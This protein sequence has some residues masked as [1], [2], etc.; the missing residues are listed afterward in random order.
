MNLGK[1]DR[2]IL[3]EEPTNT[4]DE[5]GSAVPGWSTYYQGF[6]SALDVLAGS[7]E[8]TNQDL[9]LTKRPVKIVMRYVPGINDSMRITLRDRG[10]VLQIVAPPAE[11]GRMEGLEIMCEEFSS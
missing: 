5:Y 6:A 3:I 10:R 9:R 7:R 11:I 8:A 1:L 4:Q 2:P